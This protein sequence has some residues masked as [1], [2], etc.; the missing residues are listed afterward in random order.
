MFRDIDAC[1]YIM[2]DGDDTY[3]AEEVHNLIKPIVDEEVDMVIGNRL[4][5][6]TYKQENKRRFHE[7][8]NNL[9]KNS[10]NIAFKTNLKDIMSGYR[11]FNKLF[12]KNN[13]SYES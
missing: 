8:G 5:N 2:A 1:I 3:P 4:T 10:I 7:F 6:G 12:L 11:V 9:V 13:A